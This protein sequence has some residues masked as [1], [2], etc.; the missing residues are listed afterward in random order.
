MRKSLLVMSLCAAAYA[1]SVTVEKIV[2][3]EVVSMKMFFTLLLKW[4]LSWMILIS[5]TLS[6]R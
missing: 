2:V 1:E 6:T 4:M 5:I 3:E